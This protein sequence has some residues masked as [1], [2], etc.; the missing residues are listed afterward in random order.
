MSRVYYVTVAATRALHALS[1]AF[2]AV[3]VLVVTK[4]G[5][6]CMSRCGE[7]PRVGRLW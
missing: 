3:G 7:W 2:L 6:R 4:L 5:E 1:V